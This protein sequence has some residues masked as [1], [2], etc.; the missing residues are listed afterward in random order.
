[1]KTLVI[2]I[3]VEEL[4]AHDGEIV[5][6]VCG[7]AHGVNTNKDVS[8]APP[9]FL[10]FM[11]QVIDGLAATH[12][13]RT[14]ETYRTTMHSFSLFLQGGDCPID[15]IDSPLMERYEQWLARRGV[16]PNSS[17]F[18][19]RILR[20]VYNRSVE[21]RLTT[22]RKP[23]AK[24]YTGIANTQKRAV[25]INAI[26]RLVHLDL[27]D[28][29]EAAFAR[30]LFLFSFYTQGMAFVDMALLKKSSISG[31]QLAYYRQKTGQRIT[32]KWLECM[33]DI[34]DRHP[35]A[36]DYLL[37]I[38]TRCGDTER[39]Q[40]RRSQYMVN[41]QLHALGERIGLSQRLTMYVARHSWASI[42]RAAGVPIDVISS[43][44]GHNNEQ[45]TNIYLKSIDS[46]R[47]AAANQQ[48]LSMLAL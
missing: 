10:A 40:Y 43:G 33:Q 4:M 8:E 12:K 30:D 2:R 23:F 35:S 36:N 6:N 31:G 1:M 48:V 38:I 34:V 25:D 7:H 46:G 45:T 44:M 22:D 39:S 15:V 47:I 27:S 24:V 19:M 14:V 13:P 3:P 17:S 5:I 37:P 21:Q 20:A 9:G 28:D 11:Q 16:A 29:D 18:Y 26:R 42:A 32:V 41:S